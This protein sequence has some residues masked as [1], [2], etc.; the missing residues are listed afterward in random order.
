MSANTDAAFTPERLEQS[1]QA[2][3]A[4]L[5][6]LPAQSGVDPAH[7]VLVVDGMRPALYAANDLTAAAGSYF[8]LMR[9]Y[10]IEKATG[11]GFEVIDM[12]PRFIQE[13]TADSSRFEFTAD[14]HWNGHGHEQ[15][16]KAVAS[17][18]AFGQIFPTACHDLATEG[19]R[20]LTTL[21]TFSVF[22]RIITIAPPV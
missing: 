5:T 10:F 15:A 8:D 11:R 19:S 4:F 21:N 14:H 3:D 1:R 2:V 16:A 22:R 7:T 18:K 20:V 13:Y 6:N 9:R 17:S 12:Q